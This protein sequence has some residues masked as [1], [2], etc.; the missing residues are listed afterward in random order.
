[1]AT[2]AERNKTSAQRAQ[3]LQALFSSFQE[4]DA[5]T[6][7]AAA[8]AARLAPRTA[9]GGRPPSAAPLGRV[10]ASVIENRA[11]EV[12]MAVLE[13]ATLTL[14]LSQYIEPGRQMLLQLV[15]ATEVVVVSPREAKSSR[16]AP[17]SAGFHESGVN[18]VM[19]NMRAAATA[20]AAAAAAAAVPAAAPP[21]E[22]AGVAQ[23]APAA[24]PAAAADIV[25]RHS[26][27]YDG[28]FAVYQLPRSCFDDTQGGQLLSS[29][30]RDDSQAL[31][32]AAVGKSSQYLALG[33]AGALLHHV[34]G[35][36]AVSAALG[37]PPP[38]GSGAATSAAGP[39]GALGPG[40]PVPLRAR[41]LRVEQLHAG[42]HCRLDAGLAAALEIVPSSGPT[43]P[44]GAASSLLRLLG[45]SLRTA[46]GMRLL[47]SSLLQPLAD[48]ATLD[49]RYDTIEELLQEDTLAFDLSQVIALLPKD[50]DK[51]CYSLAAAG[52]GGA[53]GGGAGGGGS[54]A[55]ANNDPG[56]GIGSLTQ[57]LL[58]LRDVLSLLEPLANTLESARSPLLTAIR[59]TC[60]DT[61]LRGLHTRV[62]EVLDEEA[63]AAAARGAPFVSRVQQCFAIRAEA[64]PD[65][66]LEV[67]RGSLCRLTETVHELGARYA[68]EMGL[69][70]L[71][72]SYSSRKGF[73]LTLPTGSG[74]GGGG[75]RK[76]RRD[77][78]GG[79]GGGGE[80]D[81]AAA[82]GMAAA[83]PAVTAE[84]LPPQLLVLEQRGNGVL[85]LTS[86]E[87]N[88]LNARLR[89]ATFD[90]LLLTR[91]LLENVVSEAFG[92]L[93]ALQRLVDGV[94][95]LDLMVG[96]A[97]VVGGGPMGQ[98]CRPQ[99]QLGGPLAIV[100]GRHPLL[101]AR[102]SS[103]AA[104]GGGGG[105]CRV[106][107]NDTFV[108][109]SAPLHVIT[110]PNMSGK[111][112]YLHQVALL[113]VMAQVGCWVP[114]QF[115]A[116]SPFTAIM[117]RLGPG[118]GGGGGGCGG[119]GPEDDMESGSSS[120]LTEMQDA[121]AVLASA[122]SRSL[123]L[124]DE[125]GR[126]TSTAD[127]VGLAWAISEELMTRGSATLLAT[128][129]PQLGELAVLYPQARLWKLHVDTAAG[130]L[131][132]RWLLQP[133]ASLD[134]CHYGL[135]LAA[136]AGLPP[137][138]V[139]EARRVAE[140]L[141][142]AERRRVEVTAAG[143]GLWATAASVCSR[144]AVLAQQWRRGGGTVEATEAALQ[145]LRGLQQ[146]AVAVPLG[147]LRREL[148]LEIMGRGRG[149]G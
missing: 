85:L 107:A 125:L 87:L 64:A 114:A 53:G 134:Y 79:G 31:V 28:G 133:A 37:A 27:V 121:A 54:A 112:T 97:E 127:G 8:A 89:D 113:V 144:L 140:L 38:R 119:G 84:A 65:G 1:M 130:Q 123:V 30:A 12:G 66:L 96:L 13:P 58:L 129:F 103:L 3:Q 98:C 15:S 42:L 11:R 139:A 20:A 74:G 18:R 73:Y 44:G 47:R 86:H 21:A 50:L 101:A 14:R 9:A 115:F 4:E 126:A 41:C 2:R 26:E 17:T 90:C 16:T 24:A 69:P 135:M 147:G 131:D 95:M 71:K 148:E 106:Q 138:I 143:S 39:P 104:G 23:G 116:L 49:M 34:L 59:S 82:G 99:L 122:T 35:Q 128:H 109:S 77:R 137:G 45:G 141:E 63:T 60:Q 19:L 56:R 48:V 57:S 7:H 146:E 61:G 111:S 102:A 124:L 51:M 105:G 72:V 5:A 10:V 92:H 108:S 36:A 33:A 40:P 22:Q 68:E 118:G 67:A 110:G 78:G 132:C 62:E 88:A 149:T 76:A 117:G 52:G 93:A 70:R 83:R 145:V 80:D 91:Q 6:G 142:E 75:G 25:V 32:A 46:A 43:G 94:A 29:Y 136:A 120:F 81:A 100:Q 55:A